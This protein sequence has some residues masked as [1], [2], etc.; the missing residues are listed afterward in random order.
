MIDVEDM[1][2]DGEIKIKICDG[3]I[4]NYRSPTSTYRVY[5]D[6][7]IEKNSEKKFERRINIGIR[8]EDYPLSNKEKLKNR[9]EH[10]YRETLAKDPEYKDYFC[11]GFEPGQENPEDVEGQVL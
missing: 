1:Q 11:K 5:A 9:L 4:R 3:G 8:N 7:W 2:I 10:E 6:A